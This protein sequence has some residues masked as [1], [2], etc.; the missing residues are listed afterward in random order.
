[1][2]PKGPLSPIFGQ[3]FKAPETL[4]DRTTAASKEIIADEREKALAKAN[5]LKAARLERAAQPLPETK[6]ARK[7]R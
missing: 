6:P 4:M 1:M 7:K 5:R 3:V 2:T